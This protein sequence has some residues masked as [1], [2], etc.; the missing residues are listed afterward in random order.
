MPTLK[1]VLYSSGHI[2]T[3]NLILTAHGG[4]CGLSLRVSCANWRFICKNSGVVQRLRGFAF[5]VRACSGTFHDKSATVRTD[6]GPLD[7]RNRRYD[8][9]RWERCQVV[10]FSTHRVASPARFEQGRNANS[11]PSPTGVAV[12][13]ERLSSNL[14]RHRPA[15]SIK[16]L[17]PRNPYNAE[18]TCS[19]RLTSAAPYLSPRRQLLIHQGIFHFTGCLDT[20]S[21]FYHRHP[22]CVTALCRPRSSSLDRLRPDICGALHQEVSLWYHVSAW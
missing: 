15:P 20:T 10:C 14:Q 7:L 8:L 4:C 12:L 16:K 2:F 5:V 21:L 11:P 1:I 3:W 19:S 22:S 6:T 17:V 9:V 13:N 18:L